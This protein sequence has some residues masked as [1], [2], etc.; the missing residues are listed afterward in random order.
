MPKEPLGQPKEEPKKLP[1]GEKPA[2]EK[3]KKPGSV[4]LIPQPV[5]TPDLDIAPTGKSPF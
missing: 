3:E 4:Q 5:V 2:P 1:S